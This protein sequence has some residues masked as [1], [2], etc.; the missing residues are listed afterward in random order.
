ME[1]LSHRSQRQVVFISTVDWNSMWQRHQAFATEFAKTGW[2]V[3]FIE[4]MGFANPSW[5]DA[6][7]LLRRMIN[8]LI[9]RKESAGWANLTKPRV[10][11]VTP[12]M[13]PPNGFFFRWVNRKLFVPM[14]RNDL[15]MR[16]L[17]RPDLAYVYLPS[18]TTLGLLKQ[19]APAKVVFDC[20]ANFRGHPRCPVDFDH[21][22][23]EILQLADVVITD[24]SFLYDYMRRKH[25]KVYQLHHGVDLD[26]FMKD[27][28]QSSFL[29]MPPRSVCF[30]GTVDE[31]L[32]WAPLLSIMEAGIEVSVIG[33]KRVR[34]PNGIRYLPPIPYPMLASELRKYDAFVIPYR[35]NE[36]TRGIVPAKLLECFALGTPTLISPIPAAW[37]Y[38]DV[39]YICSSP[40]DYVKVLMDLPSTESAEKRN[41][42]MEIARSQSTRRNFEYLLKVIGEGGSGT[43][44]T[45]GITRH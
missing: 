33:K 38:K 32:D 34:V 43:G 39:L 28:E 13:L 45:A 41:R 12:L 2:E 25:D 5:R 19:L 15:G 11:V 37:E 42:R 35:L 20:V 7:R 6:R 8:I 18:A 29:T 30:F 21:I 31:R 36:F 40:D 24:S 17:D 23:K 1:G 14:L 27:C 44:T 16:G 3:F 22:E 10:H 9:P 4:N 26:I